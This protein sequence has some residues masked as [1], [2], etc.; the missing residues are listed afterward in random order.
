MGH[1]PAVGDGVGDRPSCGHIIF[2][3]QGQRDTPPTLRHVYEFIRDRHR[4]RQR[5][6]LSI[7]S[8]FAL[9]ADLL[10]L[11]ACRLRSEISATISHVDSSEHGFGVCEQHLTSDRVADIG[12]LSDRWLYRRLPQDQWGP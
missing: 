9:T 4:A 7:V 5:L 8:E 12:C 10:P 1:G 3:S 2:V 6:W 11:L